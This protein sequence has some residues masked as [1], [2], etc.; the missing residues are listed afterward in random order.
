MISR[1][2]GTL[3]EAEMTEVLVD[4]HGVGFQVFI[5]LSTFDKLPPL[6]QTATLY[7][8]MAVKEDDIQLY[9]FATKEERRLF[10]LLTSSISGIG[11]KLSLNVLSFMSVD[12][13]VSAVA[14]QD[15]KKLC[16]INGIGKKMAERMVLELKDK[17]GSLPVSGTGNAVSAGAPVP[18][19][20]QEVDDA[21]AALETLGFKRDAASKVVQKLVEEAGDVELSAPQLIRQALSRLNG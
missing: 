19:R 20:S 17:L 4:V 14:T 16:K 7:T 2:T 6:G 9:G 15:V 10:L 13:F 1:L 12:D 3:L 11:P 21:I 18:A 8:Y 5:P